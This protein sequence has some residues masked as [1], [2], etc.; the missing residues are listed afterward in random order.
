[1]N[2]REMENYRDAQVQ[3]VGGLADARGKE[4]YERMSRKIGQ[5]VLLSHSP[6]SVGRI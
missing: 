6:E 5:L 4:I 1:M 3:A 2:V